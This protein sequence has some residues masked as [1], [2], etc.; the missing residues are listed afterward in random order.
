MITVSLA[1]HPRLS[2]TITIYSPAVKLK[3][4]SVVCT[5]IVFQE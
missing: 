3:A 4:V 5:G 1:S 2:A